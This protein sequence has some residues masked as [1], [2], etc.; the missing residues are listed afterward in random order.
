MPFFN[1]ISRKGWKGDEK[2]KGE[3][4]SVESCGGR[5]H[6]SDNVNPISILN[7]LGLVWG[8]GGLW[9]CQQII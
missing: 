1:L 7:E 8:K 2:R 3:V 6:A 5:D 9:K 4:K